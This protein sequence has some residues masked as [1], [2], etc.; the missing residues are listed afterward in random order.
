MDS[1]YKLLTKDL[2]G[3]RI[4]VNSVDYGADRVQTLAHNR[5]K[6][7]KGLAAG[8]SW[9]L[10]DLARHAKAAACPHQ[11]IVLAGFSQ[12]AMVMH[13]VLH[14]LGGTNAGR[15]VLA[16]VAAAVLVGDGDQV[17]QDRQLRYG[18]ASDQAQGIGQAF[19]ALS[20]SLTA[21][22]SAQLDSRV[23]SVCNTHDPV[24][25]FTGADL[26][27][28]KIHL[29]YP[30]S[31]PLQAAAEQ[32]ARDLLGKPWSATRIPSLAGRLGLNST[33]A[34]SCPSEFS[35]VAVGFG[36]ILSLSGTRWT[37]SPAPLPP[38]GT[39]WYTL[40]AVICPIIS[41][42]VAVGSYRDS[43][44]NLHGVL[45]ARSGTS[46][47]ATEA[48]LPAPSDSGGVLTDVSCPTAT[49]CVAIGTYS[50]SQKG[51]SGLILTGSGALWTAHRA[52]LPPNSVAGGGILD[53]S[54][55]T[56]AVAASCVV[57]G[58]YTDAP[59]QQEGLLVTWSGLQWAAS[60]A[61]LPPRQHPRYPSVSLKSISCPSLSRC[62]AVGFYQACTSQDHRGLLLTRSGSTWSA[63][64]APVPP[65]T[66]S[67][68]QDWLFSVSCPSVAF[69][70]ATGG[71]AENQE[72]PG[73]VVTW[74]GKSWTAVKPP[75]PAPYQVG[76]VE[77]IACP[78]ASSCIATGW[79]NYAGGLL[80]Q[81]SRT[82]WA[83]IQAPLPPIAGALSGANVVDVACGS[84][85]ACSA[86]M[87][88]SDSTGRH[89]LLLTGPA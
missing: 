28:F 30:A 59:S 70:V 69:C 87:G 64:D 68:H 5:Q 38:G 13:R 89:W 29:S 66:A 19:R 55:V 7:F 81:G 58:D 57:I 83:A 76:A 25:D 56:C 1:V 44:G 24:C 78:S 67:A 60:E 3:Q 65:G 75:A 35:C 82:Y 62:V 32:A 8:V 17:P 53:L 26:V 50:D 33:S 54:S 15:M 37:A 88:Y 18:S 51:T 31:R 40:P 73:M 34:I 61:P 41:S 10:Q 14:L 12:G 85:S 52:P 46:W 42:C 84:T 80:L 43:A 4:E 77:D 6:Y 49:S 23:L 71:Y 72:S 63:A 11:R 86:L 39:A 9:T 16:R 20:H 48:P 74:S 47:T 27:N 22:F 79:Y 21:V 2:G 45:L 36:L